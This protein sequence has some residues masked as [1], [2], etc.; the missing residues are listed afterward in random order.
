[1]K[2]RKQNLNCPVGWCEKMKT[3]I[4]ISRLMVIFM[5][6]LSLASCDNPTAPQPRWLTYT[7]RF[8]KPISFTEV[9][10][11]IRAQGEK[12]SLYKGS[13]G[14]SGWSAWQMSMTQGD[15]FS[16]EVKALEPDG[17]VSVDVHI[18]ECEWYDRGR[19]LF[20]EKRESIG[21]T[22]AVSVIVP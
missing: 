15:Y 14:L 21:G 10:R 6:I 7:V 16:L 19:V 1:V 18:E 2:C 5:V 3:S 4:G 17:Y 11:D 12:D 9:V 20:Q 22:V 13:D 8:D